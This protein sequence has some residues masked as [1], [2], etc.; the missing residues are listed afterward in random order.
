MGGEMSRWLQL[1]R[2]AAENPASLPDTPTEPDKSPSAVPE[3]AFCPL[4][5]GCRVENLEKDRSELEE[6]HAPSQ[7]IGNRPRCWQGKVV[8][9]T[10]WKALSDWERWGPQGATW[11][12]L[13]ARWEA[14]DPHEQPKG[15]QAHGCA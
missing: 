7:S 15:G 8:S 13:T 3:Q 14:A 10:E 5:S 6:P 4:L 1:V 2:K 9:I 11:N 12:P